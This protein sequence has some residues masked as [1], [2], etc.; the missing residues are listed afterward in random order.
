MSII[1]ET[2]EIMQSHGD[3]ERITLKMKSGKIF[4]FSGGTICGLDVCQMS[5]WEEKNNYPGCPKCGHGS[6]I[7]DGPILK[8]EN[9]DYKFPI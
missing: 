8:C 1:G 5:L 2:V 4:E 7:K 6:S 9:C 3:N